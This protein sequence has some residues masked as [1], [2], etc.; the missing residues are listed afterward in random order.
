VADRDTGGGANVEGGVSTDGGNL[1]GRDDRRNQQRY[2][3]RN[4]PQQNVNIGGGDGGHFQMWA[5][6]LEHGMEIQNLV[7]QMDNLPDRVTKL[8]RLEVVVKPG[9]EVVIKQTATSAGNFSMRA[10]FVVLIIALIV[11]ISLVA[12]L[13][14]WQVSRG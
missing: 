5:K 4:D 7:R 11:V 2:D 8:E 14:Y 13:V 6:I 1:T 9:P 3:N 12:F 10:L